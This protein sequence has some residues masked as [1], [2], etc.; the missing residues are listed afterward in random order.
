MVKLS[1]YDAA[2]YLKTEE[3]VTYFLAA[4]AEENDPVF[5]AHALGAAARA[6]GMSQLA[7][8]TG[9]SRMGLI[10]ALSSE[11]NPS[12]A[13]ISKVLDALGYR[14][15]IVPKS[16]PSRFETAEGEEN[17]TVM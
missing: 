5:T 3:D 15:D 9:I 10:K 2:D 17:S 8:E 6:Y 7:R 11:G 4:M 13:T 14:F 16:T 12:F 1:R